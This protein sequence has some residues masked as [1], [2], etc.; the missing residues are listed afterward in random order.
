MAAL[1][2]GWMPRSLATRVI[3]VGVLAM[4]VAAC[5][6]GLLVIDIDAA[7]AR[8]GDWPL[9]AGRIALATLAMLGGGVALLRRVTGLVSRLDNSRASLAFRNAE[10]T[11]ASEQLA[12]SRA[13]LE[14]QSALLHTTLETMDQGLMVVDAAQSVVI[15]NHQAMEMLD[16][17]AELMARRPAFAEVLAFQRSRDEFATADS[18]VRTLIDT[19]PLLDTPHY[20]RRRPNGQVIEIRST[21]LPDGGVVRTYTDITARRAAEDRIRHAAH[22]DALTQ[23]CNRAM[24]G[25]QL[26]AALLAAQR[27]QHSLAVLYLDLDHFKQVNDQ[28]G[29]AAGDLLLTE[30]ARRMRTA[31]RE[32]ATVARMGGDE[33]AIIQPNAD[34]PDSTMTVARRL[35]D[36]VAAPYD[37]HGSPAAIGVSIGIAFYPED[38]LTA[39]DLLRHA[40]AALYDAKRNG[41]NTARCFRATLA[42]G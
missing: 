21:R 37:L 7:R 1:R 19:R 9:H 28:L 8:H 23:L 2:F 31:V 15:C 22:H 18:A 39:E 36:R 5:M 4:A 12:Q 30:A 26:E 40:D 13:R 41:R 11:R 17:P 38:G 14:A 20:E 34:R 24:F 42:G 6:I 29:H 27:D 32:T 33:F 25:E 3:V 35:L 10:I 16:L